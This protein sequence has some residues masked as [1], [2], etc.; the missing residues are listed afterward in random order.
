MVSVSSSHHSRNGQ[1][2]QDPFHCVKRTKNNPQAPTIDGDQ[3]MSKSNSENKKEWQ[4]A[5]QSAKIDLEYER[6]RLVNAELQTECESSLWEHH[7]MNME[8]FS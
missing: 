6:L 2:R 1:P 7:A 5:I 3:E 4:D 8:V